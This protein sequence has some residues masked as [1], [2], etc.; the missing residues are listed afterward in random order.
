MATIKKKNTL[1]GKKSAFPKSIAPML[2]T[3]VDEPFDSDD[4][5]Y[6]IKWDG[7]RALAFLDKGKVSLKSRNDK[8]FDEK[9]YA[10][11]DE[12]K[13]WKI[14]AVVDGEIIVAD[15]DG[16][17]NFGNLQN[18]RSE[19]DGNLVFYVFD[20]LWMDGSSLM[21]EE[22]TVRR[23]ILEKNLPKSNSILLS[24][25]FETS[26]ISFFKSAE[27]MKLEGIMAKRKSSPYIPG[28][29]SKDWLKIKT[30]SR[31]EVVIGGY[32]QNEG[33][34]KLFSSLLVGVYQK[35]KLVYTGKI[36]TGFT[37]K[38]QADMIKQ[39]KKYIAKKSPFEQT[40]D[41]NKPS[42]FRH[43][44][45][46]AKAVWLKPDLICE[47]SFREMT[48]DGVMRHPS[49][50]GMRIDKKAKDVILETKT[51]S[52]KTAIGKINDYTRSKNRTQFFIKSIR[53][54]AGS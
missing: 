26:G 38:M 18:W 11:L 9:F 2:A 6:E 44:P 14:N 35:N 27:K 52:K 22:L 7:Y 45:P 32:T 46:N 16:L 53:G 28:S 33:S 29:R 4:W 24:K 40:P 17:P 1:S 34:A 25:S 39:F 42:R 50:Q 13:K 47:V 23:S 5:L 51:I 12:L 19:A 43:D 48:S 36:G 15:K 10:I 41:I 37:E 8:S 49:F 54:A 31:Q 20:I 21:D 3:L 30:Q